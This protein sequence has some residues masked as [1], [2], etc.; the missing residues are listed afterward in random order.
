LHI[1]KP[2]EMEPN[3]ILQSSSWCHCFKFRQCFDYASWVTAY[4]K[5]RASGPGNPQ[6][7]VSLTAK[8]SLL[9]Q[10]EDNRGRTD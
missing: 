3:H 10:V 7:S 2:E 4:G 6:K 1:G 5:P 9:S 8:S